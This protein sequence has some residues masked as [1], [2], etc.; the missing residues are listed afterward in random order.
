[1]TEHLFSQTINQKSLAVRFNGPWV[2]IY[3]ENYNQSIETTEK[4]E[5]KQTC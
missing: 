4:R 3:L 1:M 5:R 2:A